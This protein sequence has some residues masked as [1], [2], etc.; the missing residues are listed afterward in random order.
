[1]LD[2]RILPPVDAE[3]IANIAANSSLAGVAWRE[4]GRAPLGYI[5]G[6]AVMF[7]VVARKLAQGDSAASRWPK[8]TSGDRR[9][10]ALAHYAP[11]FAALGMRNDV[12]GIDT[13]RH[14]FVLLIG[15]GLRELSGK[16]CEGYDREPNRDPLT[17]E[18]AEAGLFQMSW[19]AR[20]I[21]PF[22]RQLFDDYQRNGGGYKSIFAEGVTCTA[23]NLENVGSGDGLRFQQICKEMPGFAVEAA[24]I[25]LRHA[26]GEKGHW[27][28]IRRHEAE[29]RREADEML[30]QVQ[31]A[32]GGMATVPS[33]PTPTNRR[34]EPCGCSSHST[35]SAPDRRLKRTAR[36]DR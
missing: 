12:N 22:I 3:T 21:S 4:R 31:R 17:S 9:H 36:T 28:P 2:R 30:Q 11:Q 8:P 35:S 19:N 27:G 7:A 25:G 18:S 29:L 23:K 20:S 34:T 1:M 33:G 16:Y 14:L 10:D 13:L 24:A 5:K 15:L 32:M 26:G 6:M